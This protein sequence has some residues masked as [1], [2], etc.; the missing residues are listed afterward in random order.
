MKKWFTLVMVAWFA[1][2][3]ISL[4]ASLATDR[5]EERRLALESARAYALQIGTTR[6]WNAKHNG[7]YTFVDRNNLPNPYLVDPERDLTI[8]DGRVLTKI[9]PAYMTRQLSELAASKSGYQFRMTSLK[10]LNPENEPTAWEAEALRKFEGGA[11]EFSEYLDVENS[12]YFAYMAPFTVT[13]ECMACHAAQG[14]KVG[15]V[16]GGISITIVDPPTIKTRGLYFW[17]VLIGLAGALFILAMGKTVEDAYDKVRLEAAVDSLTRLPNRRNLMDRYRQELRLAHRQGTSLA[18]LMID[19][20]HFKEYNDTK[21]HVA[22]DHCLTLVA[23]VI[24]DALHRPSDI[25]GRYGGEE[26]MVVMPDSGKNGAAHVAER[27]RAGVEGLN[28]H[29]GGASGGEVV[30]VSVGVSVV[31]GL[32]ITSA[33]EIALV[34]EADDALYR[35]K[36]AGRNR[37]EPK[38]V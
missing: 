28:M 6:E 11:K 2:V 4:W 3:S 1:M 18:L 34:N 21:G 22:G 14:Y 26:F 20:D 9:N 25:C 7:V 16:R 30:T 35:A 38:A 12:R 17:H 36:A 23:G 19:V 5:S 32:N 8:S 33:T 31:E 15:D 27:I 13:G 10:P 37:V 29:H 24:K